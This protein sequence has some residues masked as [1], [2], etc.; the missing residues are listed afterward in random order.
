MAAVMKACKFL[1][2]SLK[3]GVSIDFLELE[4]AGKREVL[5]LDVGNQFCKFEEETHPAFPEPLMKE[6]QATIFVD[7]S[8]GHG[9][10]TCKSFTGVIGLLGSTPET[11][12]AK[13]LS[14]AMTATFGAE[15]SSLK[16]KVK[17]AIAC[18]HH[19]RAFGMRVPKPKITHEDNMAVVIN[20]S[21]P[22]SML[23]HEYVPLSFHF[24]REQCAEEVVQIRHVKSKSNLACRLT[25]G[26]DS[27]NFNTCF[28]PL[29]CN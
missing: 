12:S 24:C 7:S 22:G 27:S 29:M 3:R 23:Q 28:L 26:I 14:L 17:E 13:R 2:T 25:K 11:W 21:E 18:R 20:S 15:L 8:H 10:A 4:Q 19:C 6:T 16:K 5:K 9:K 1:K